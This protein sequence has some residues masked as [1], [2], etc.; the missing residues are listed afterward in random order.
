MSRD[1]GT[2]SQDQDQGY[3]L[4]CDVN[5]KCL[6]EDL[7]VVSAN[8][9]HGI[10][11][12]RDGSEVDFSHFPIG[13]KVRILPNHACSTAAQYDKYHVIEKGQCVGSW[14]RIRGW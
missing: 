13:E 2:A 7:I 9:E 6:D 5:G 12:R 14:S 10:I 1:R 3:G 4:V 11:G 8:Q